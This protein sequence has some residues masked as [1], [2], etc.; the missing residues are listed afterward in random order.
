[1]SKSL[2]TFC[3]ASL[4][5]VSSV[6]GLHSLSEAVLFLSLTLFGLVSSKHF[7]Y[8]LDNWIRKRFQRS[9]HV[10]RRGKQAKFTLLHNDILYYTR[11]ICIL[12]RGFQ[13]FS[14]FFEKILTFHKRSR[15]YIAD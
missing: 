4:E 3:A 12:S 1:M 5:N 2:S 15:Q 11:C 9:N 14:W 7:F 10:D 13:N 8:L 6:S